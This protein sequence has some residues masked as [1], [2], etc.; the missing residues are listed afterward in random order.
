MRRNHKGV[1][2]LV[3]AVLLFLRLVDQGQAIYSDRATVFPETS[4]LAPNS[5]R[6][7]FPSYPRTPTTN[8]IITI[9]VSGLWSN[10]FV[11]LN[12]RPTK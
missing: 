5:D 2:V 3:G 10:A 12:T 6:P 4:S 9:L 1:F 7:S 11:P 8:D